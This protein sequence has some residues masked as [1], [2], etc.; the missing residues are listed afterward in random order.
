MIARF[1]MVSEQPTFL[2]E[3]VTHFNMVSEQPTQ[4]LD[5]RI[6]SPPIIK[7]KLMCLT[8]EKESNPHVRKCVENIIK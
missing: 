6:S 7:K 3:M 8:R 1:N 4:I 2:D 5:D